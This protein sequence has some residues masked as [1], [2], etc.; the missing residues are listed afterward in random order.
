MEDNFEK[1][2]TKK[3]G[4]I[5]AVVAVILIA[6]IV[7]GVIFLNSRKKPEKIFEKTVEDIF[8]MTER[9]SSKSGRIALEISGEIDAD[10]PEI[11]E[12]NEF[13]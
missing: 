7:V 2:S 1:K 3:V 8:E 11:K 10:D 9:E 12:A 13:L 4:I 5:I 6:A